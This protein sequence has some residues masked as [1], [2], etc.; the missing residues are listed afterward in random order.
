MCENNGK[1]AKT[2]KKVRKHWVCF[3]FAKGKRGGRRGLEN[4][5]CNGWR[6]DGN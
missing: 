6:Q 2:K 5:E 4:E 3:E 1:S